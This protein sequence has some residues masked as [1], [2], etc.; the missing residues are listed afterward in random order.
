M[1]IIQKVPEGKH[2]LAGQNLSTRITWPTET[3]SGPVSASTRVRL[4]VP[5]HGDHA[6]IGAIESAGRDAVCD[7]HGL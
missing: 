1:I 5:L 4:V 7:W 3:K 2:L 6:V